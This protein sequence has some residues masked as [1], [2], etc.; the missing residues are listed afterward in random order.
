[1]P[2]PQGNAQCVTLGARPLRRL[3][4]LRIGGANSAERLSE[5]QVM[6]GP[7]RPIEFSRQAGRGDRQGWPT[8]FK[9]T[10]QILDLKLDRRGYPTTGAE[11]RGTDHRAVRSQLPISHRETIDPHLADN[12]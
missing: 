10:G 2:S 7:A 12:P 5:G 6:T 8:G 3:V 1:M 9:S 11:D 4:L